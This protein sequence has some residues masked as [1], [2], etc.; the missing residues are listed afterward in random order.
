MGLKN[1]FK[2]IEK[3]FFIALIFLIIQD[4]ITF[5]FLNLPICSTIS[6][7]NTREANARRKISENSLSRPPIP[8]FSKFQ[9]GLIIDWRFSLVLALPMSN[10]YYIMWNKDFITK[11]KK[12][13]LPEHPKWVKKSYHY[14]YKNE[15]YNL[16]WF[17]RKKGK[18]C[19]AIYFVWSPYMVT[20]CQ[21]D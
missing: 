8:I 12:T 3:R 19:Y 14:I 16:S 10:E 13:E 9:S 21:N 11:F 1:N 17:Y 2:T 18:F 4:F 20:R 6:G 7:G 15:Q 5:S